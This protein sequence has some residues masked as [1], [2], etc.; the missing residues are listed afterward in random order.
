VNK[1][2][3]AAAAWLANYILLHAYFRT[4]AAPCCAST[5]KNFIKYI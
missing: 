5:N 2:A 3:D 4:T 1:T